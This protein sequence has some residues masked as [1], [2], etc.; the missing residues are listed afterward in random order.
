[1]VYVVGHISIADL[2][3]RYGPGEASSARWDVLQA[4]H[5]PTGYRASSALFAF[6]VLLVS[7]E[8]VTTLSRHG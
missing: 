3:H 7:S 4:S 8:W 2:A 5:R 6:E 1:M